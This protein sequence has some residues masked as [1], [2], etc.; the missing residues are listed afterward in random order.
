MK[1]DSLVDFANAVST[2]VGKFTLQIMLSPEKI[3]SP[4]F[5]LPNLKWRS[6]KYGKSGLD[7]VP[8]DK[9]GVYAFAVCKPSKVLP[10]HGFVLYIGIAGRDSKRSLRQRYA[11]YLNP[12]SVIKR[13]RIARMIGTWH[14]V[15]RFYYAPVDDTV[16]SAELKQLEMELNT[17]LTP[18]FSEGD[19]EADIKQ[20]RRAFR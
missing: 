20:K 19:I 8:D 17:A 12:R 18:V 13:V 3:L 4:T 14:E 11:D 1:L 16:S 7:R 10:P 6:I 9:R 2:D 15:L 5:T